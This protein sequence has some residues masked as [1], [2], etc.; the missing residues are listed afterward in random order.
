[1]ETTAC[2]LQPC[3]NDA[4]TGFHVHNDTPRPW[5]LVCRPHLDALAADHTLRASLH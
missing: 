2:Q 4:V 5:V 1:M 3:P